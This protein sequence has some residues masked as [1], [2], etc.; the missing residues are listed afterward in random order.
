MTYVS[1][2]L[3]KLVIERANLIHESQNI[4][5]ILVVGTLNTEPKNI[6]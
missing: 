2:D 1:A 5:K 6:P 4:K 3:R